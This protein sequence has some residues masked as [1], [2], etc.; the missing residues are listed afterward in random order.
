MDK[1]KGSSAGSKTS[2]N[3][4]DFEE[5]GEGEGGAGQA[6]EG[7][8]EFGGRVRTPRKGEVVGIVTQRY[9]GNRMEVHGTDGKKRNCRVPGRYKK[10]LWLRPRDVVLISIWP[11][12]DSKGD[13]IFK[14]NPSAVSK[15]RRMGVLDS[16]KTDF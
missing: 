10:S 16:I 8:G 15:L 4:G 11:D 12:D 1:S 7:E 6:V 13:I 3:F 14:Y 9:G 2:G 5:V